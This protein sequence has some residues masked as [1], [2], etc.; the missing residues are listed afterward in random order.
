MSFR[1]YV[2]K[3]GDLVHLNFSPSAG[4]EMADRHY[5]LVLSRD[6]YNNRTGMAY[7]VPITSR[8][9]GWPFEVPLPA[10]LLPDKHGAGIVKSI[11][12]ADVARH[13]DYREREM[14][15][16]NRAPPELVEEVLDLLLEVLQE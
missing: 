4:H 11:L 6:E 3:R 15:F 8:I 5:A 14:A 13:V 2:P 10:G 7:V 1:T 12:H 16:V 9:R